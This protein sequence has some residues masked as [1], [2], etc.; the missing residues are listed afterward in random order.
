MIPSVPVIILGVGLLVGLIFYSL[1]IGSEV[2]LDFDPVSKLPRLT[3][4][5]PTLPPAS[6][7]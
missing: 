1:K 6:T 4:K 2:T 7:N 5:P 3:I